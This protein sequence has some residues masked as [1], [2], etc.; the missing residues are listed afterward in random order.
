MGEFTPPFGE[1]VED[2][3]TNISSSKELVFPKASLY[4]TYIFHETNSSN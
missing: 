1:N 3:D 4:G 2:I